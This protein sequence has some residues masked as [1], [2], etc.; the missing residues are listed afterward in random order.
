MA[1]LFARHVLLLGGENSLRAVMSGTARL[2]QGETPA[3]QQG[4][5]N[6]WIQDQGLIGLTARYLELQQ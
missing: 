4:M 2:G 1:F 5:S 3:S 6:Q